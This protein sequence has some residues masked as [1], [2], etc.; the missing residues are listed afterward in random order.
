V[1]RFDYG[2]NH[3]FFCHFKFNV[4]LHGMT[5][6]THCLRSSDGPNK[7]SNVYSTAPQLDIEYIYTVYRVPERHESGRKTKGHYN[8]LEDANAA[9]D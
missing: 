3:S 1:A 8:Y 6:S 9:A 2:T 4:S 5:K 7:L